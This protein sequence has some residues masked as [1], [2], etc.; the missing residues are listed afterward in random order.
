MY[1]SSKTRFG[2]TIGAGAEYAPDASWT[3]KSEYLYTD[4][5]KSTVSAAIGID[6]DVAFH[7]VR[8]GL[9]YRF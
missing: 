2:W 5:G 1:R 3:L 9:N 8:A 4:F 6:N 7:L